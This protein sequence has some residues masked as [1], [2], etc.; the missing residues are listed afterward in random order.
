MEVNEKVES[1][2]KW[3]EKGGKDLAFHLCWHEI[4][5]LAGMYET[6]IVNWDDEDEDSDNNDDQ[7]DDDS[8]VLESYTDCAH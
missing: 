7:S 2:W 5:M 6:V 1:V 3:D 8:S 4:K